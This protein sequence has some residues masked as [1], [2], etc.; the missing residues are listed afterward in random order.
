MT[1]DNGQLRAGWKQQLYPAC[2][3]QQ[4]VQATVSLCLTDPA[5]RAG[6]LII[7]WKLE[8]S[9]QQIAVEISCE[10]ILNF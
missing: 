2:P 9:A 6:H 1:A 10:N 3:G 8:R 5:D 4:V 7:A